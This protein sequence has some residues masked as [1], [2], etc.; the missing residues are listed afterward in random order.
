MSKM[1]EVKRVKFNLPEV[2]L[3]EL[4]DNLLERIVKYLPWKHQYSMKRVNVRFQ[5]LKYR[6]S[7]T[8]ELSVKEEQIPDDG[9][10]IFKIVEMLPKLERLYQLEHLDTRGQFYWY[11]DLLVVGEMN[12]SEERIARCCPHIEEFNTEWWE[13]DTD[14]RTLIP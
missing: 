12:G 13:Y 5:K 6:D 2:Q 9:E 11:N 8:L 7:T 10:T 14:K 1:S 4:T 3:T